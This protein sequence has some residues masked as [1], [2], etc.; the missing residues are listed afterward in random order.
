[1]SSNHWFKNLI[2]FRFEQPFSLTTEQLHE[3]LH[4]FPFQPCPSFAWSSMGWI[5]PAEY[6]NETQLVYAANRCFL[7][8]LR[9]QEKIL[10]ATV[11]RDFVN[12]KVE[13]IEEE[14][15]R[16]VR[17]REKDA[18]KEQIIE[19]LLPRAFVKSSDISAYIDLEHN[20]LLI[21][22]ASRKKA[23]ELVSF[24]RKCL[25]SLPVVPVEVDQSPSYTMTGWLTRRNLPKPFTLGEDCKLVSTEGESV[26][27]KQLDLL[28]NE[29]Q[30]HLNTGKNV[31][32][33]A[34]QWQDR[35]SFV[36]DQEYTIKRIRF[37]NISEDQLEGYGADFSIMSLEFR[38]F[39]TQLLQIFGGLRQTP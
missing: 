34:L 36:I 29:V 13:Q 24:L 39:I 4:T 6:E 10:P 20:W 23:D 35:I 3:Q 12:E 19:E 37:L 32:Y 25:G 38:Q 7:I 26:T 17:R 9:K 30:E 16:E 5:S 1:M 22:T 11:I 18:I 14:Q 2:I 15:Q 28:S 8:T 21:N 33:L 31:N 27:C